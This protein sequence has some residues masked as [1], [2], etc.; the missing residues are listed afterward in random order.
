MTTLAYSCTLMSPH[1]A[2]DRLSVH[3]VMF[4][5]LEA[6][7][8][9]LFTHWSGQAYVSLNSGYSCC[10]QCRLSL[11]PTAHCTF[12]DVFPH[13]EPAH[14]ASSGLSPMLRLSRHLI[15]P[16]HTAAPF[17][18]H[19]SYFTPFI[20]FAIILLGNISAWKGLCHW[21]KF[22]WKKV[23]WEGWKIILS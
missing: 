17:E 14:C 3:T 4:V 6:T 10:L 7:V 12:S 16:Q 22:F 8:F 18:G 1:W 23:K 15:L 21:Y 5:C 9:A 19:L 11:G 2:V 20:G 13:T